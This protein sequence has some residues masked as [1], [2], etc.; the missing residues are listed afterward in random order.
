[1]TDLK[2]IKLVPSGTRIIGLRLASQ[3]SASPEQKTF[4]W[5]QLMMHKEGTDWAEKPEAGIEFVDSS[6]Y[7]GGS[8]PTPTISEP[9][10]AE[11]TASESKDT[12]E[13]E[14]P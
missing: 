12:V 5:I 8:S 1:M 7:P 4:S 10:K 9:S 13:V 11:P 3:K 2:P 14:D 6:F